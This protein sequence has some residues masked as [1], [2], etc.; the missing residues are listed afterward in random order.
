MRVVLRHSLLFLALMTSA[1]GAMACPELLN[2]SF[3]KLQDNT[4][5]SLCQYEGKVLLVVNTASKCGYTPQ[6]DGLETLF[7]RFKEKGLVVV[8]F[9]SN[10]FGS[11]EP[12]TNKEIADFCRLTY[13]VKFP[14]L[15]KTSVVQGKANPF[16]EALAK[17]TGQRPEWNFHKYLIDRSGTRVQSFP[18]RVSPESPELKGAV[19]RLLAAQ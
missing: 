11:Q 8:G 10:D 15:G 9:P 3:P 14:M 1:G 2:H 18:S 17:A 13:G 6:Y 19:E 7:D 12:G 16:Y 4:S 5:Q